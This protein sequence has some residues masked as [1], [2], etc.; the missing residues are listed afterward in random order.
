MS[1]FLPRVPSQRAS[2][3]AWPQLPLTVLMLSHRAGRATHPHHVPD[4]PGCETFAEGGEDADVPP[5]SI[6]NAPKGL[7]TITD[8]VA[9][10]GP[11]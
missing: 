10:V 6:S 2:R 7:S 5:I 4:S 8:S 3:T 11:A 1:M 9:K